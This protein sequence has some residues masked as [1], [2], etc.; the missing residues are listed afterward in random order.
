VSAAAEAVPVKYRTVRRLAVGGMGEIFLARE[1]GRL[2]RLVVIKKM[3]P[4]V[5]SST[6]SVEMFVDEARIISHLAH[7]NICQIL[8]LGVEKDGLPFLVLEYVRGESVAALW[9]R[10]YTQKDRV[11]IA[12]TLR[13]IAEAARAL[14]FA[15]EATDADGKPLRIIHRDVTP[16]NLMVTL[17][18]DVKLMDFGV[19]RADNQQHR[20]DTGQIK[21]KIAYMSPEQLR[22]KALDRRADVFALGVMLWEL[23]LNRR[24]FRGADEIETLRKAADGVVP[25]PTSIDPTY[26]PAL[27]EIVL[28]AL[29]AKRDERTASAGELAT[30]LTEQM[31]ALG[32][33]DRTALAEHLR[34]LFPQKSDGVDDEPT[35]VD[36][37]VKYFQT[38]SLSIVDEVS[39]K[40]RPTAPL[41]V[42]DPAVHGQ[43]TQL[44]RRSEPAAIAP[45]PVERASTTPLVQMTRASNR[46]LVAGLLAIA[47][48][49]GVIAVIVTRGHT[50]PSPP[51]ARLPAA[52][53]KAPEPIATKATPEPVT[54]TE[55]PTETTGPATPPPIAEHKPGGHKTQHTSTPAQTTPTV[56]AEPA[57]KAD[58]KGLLAVASD[59]MGV[60]VI[61]GVRRKSTP[62]QTALPVGRHDVTLEL[63]EGAG[64]LHASVETVVGRKTKCMAK[65]GVLAC[66]TPP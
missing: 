47:V 29:A 9:D 21:G 35:V 20:T 38:A 63:A 40:R 17:D 32:G 10:A 5:A 53:D 43:P 2:S 8:E 28:R 24:L 13:I 62:F 1:Q 57:V 42:S 37:E 11:P 61:D 33:S 31:A 12:M 39:S 19:A 14:H 48:A 30:A 27:E 23:T 15:H 52:Q 49:A 66:D 7:P 41:R 54:P 6:E 22:G 51:I 45:A 64:T 44:L 65:G 26:P 16:H 58:E 50:P 60:V 46:G 55:T 36:P 56:V 3:L 59:Q 34:R 25:R 18:G 4:Q